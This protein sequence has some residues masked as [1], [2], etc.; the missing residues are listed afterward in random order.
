MTSQRHLR[1]VEAELPARGPR[2]RRP[3]PL[4]FGVVPPDQRGAETEPVPAAPLDPLAAAALLE[5]ALKL[6][7]EGDAS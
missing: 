2:G 3:A 1:L 5:F 4:T 7:R 6:C